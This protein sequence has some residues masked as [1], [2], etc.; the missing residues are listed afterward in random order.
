MASSPHQT[1]PPHTPDRPCPSCAVDDLDD[2]QC[3]AAGFK[4]RSEVMEAQ[5]NNLKTRRASFDSARKDYST[6]RT[7]AES[8][9]AEIRRQLVYIVEQ[10]RCS[11]KEDVVECLESAHR[12]VHQKLQECGGEVG[13]CIGDCEFDASVEGETS[14]LHAK[15]KD[16]EAKVVKAEAC[17]DR[18]AAE[19]AELPKRVKALKTAVEALAGTLKGQ[20]KKADTR[21]SYA[22]A[23]VYQQQRSDIWLGFDNVNDYVDCLCKGLSCSVRGRTALAALEGE[24]AVRACKEQK[25]KERC[26]W[27]GANVVEEILAACVAETKQADAAD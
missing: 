18:L 17:F 5:G 21:R 24:V 22:W 8:D 12:D 1:K 13:C 20:P 25:A 19:P 26:D 16:I 27:L 4:R 23:L 9:V 2:L 3:E 7:D 6:A 14:A 10:L 15:L 11:L